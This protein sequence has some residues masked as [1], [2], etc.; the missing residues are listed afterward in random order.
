MEQIQDGLIILF[1]NA[2]EVPG[3]HTRQD[4]DFYYFTGVED[5]G[6]ITIMIPK[7]KQAVLFLP[8]QTDR[9]HQLKTSW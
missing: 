7:L 6:A 8:A 2:M 4:N 9:E 5:L 3:A 1:G